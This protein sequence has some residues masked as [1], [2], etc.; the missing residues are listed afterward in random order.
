LAPYSPEKLFAYELGLKSTLA[1]G[2]LQLNAA[3][4]YYDWR[5][6][7]VTTE[8]AYGT[9]ANVLEVVVL[10]DAGNAEIKGLDS[11]LTWR[12]TPEW[13]LRAGFN[14]MDPKIVTG[15]YQS[16]TPVQSPKVSANVA[17]RY[18]ASHPVSKLLP[19]AQIDYNYRSSVYFTLPNKVADSQGGY[20]QLGA[21]AGVG[22]EDSKWE[23]SAWA[24]NLTDKAYL[25]DAFGAGSSLLPDRH[26]FAEP[27]TFG[28][29]VRY[30][31]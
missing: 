7:Q 21:R 25:V 17:L 26:L 16:M 12:I 11:D 27:R 24:R 1:N 3:A 31:F 30:E 6:M 14:L 23:W 4:Y 19:F 18:R 5:N 22:T 2:Q 15:P 20:G 13:S 28:L 10:G 9:G 29:S 8:V